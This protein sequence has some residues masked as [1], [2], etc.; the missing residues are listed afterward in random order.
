M[1]ISA[2]SDMPHAI[3]ANTGGFIPPPPDASFGGEPATY[4][5]AFST[6]TSGP[7]GHQQ[8]T[9]NGTPYPGSAVHLP[10]PPIM[11]PSWSAASYPPHSVPAWMAGG[12]GATPAGSFGLASPA[13]FGPTTPLGPHPGYVPASPYS[14]TPSSV[15]GQPMLG[16]PYFPAVNG[17]GRKA[18]GA[19]S[20]GGGGGALGLTASP[21][22]DA[23]GY[24]SSHG[25]LTNSKKQG[26]VLQ[27][28]RLAGNK[29]PG[30]RNDYQLWNGPEV[31][32][33]RNLARRPRDWRPDYN[34]RS[35]FAS[36]I[37][38]GKHRSDIPEYTDP[39]KRT[40]NS[41]LL[42]K[43]GEPAT[44][45]NLRLDPY[46]VEHIE[47]NALSR[48]HND[49]DLIQLATSP[50]ADQLR[51]Y[52][53]K[54]PWYIDVFKSRPNGITIA[55]I[56]QAMWVQLSS[57]IHQ[58]HY[59]NEELDDAHRGVLSAAFSDRCGNVKELTDR[60]VLQVDFLAERYVF[61][62]LVKGKNGMWEMKTATED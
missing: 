1:S 26:D 21:S 20:G 9:T 36:Y 55:D 24:P 62:G 44:Y 34:P 29:S 39:V 3:D 49:I 12:G 38:L 33:L 28:L 5:D 16:T 48:P 54:L 45:W 23:Y 13:S 52:H 61:L 46:H 53:P 37:S 31:Y 7:S 51:F 50:P 11:T 40:L 2:W 32:S 60:G 4:Y 59:Y 35:G 14:Y 8:R 43:T 10:A 15:G 18:G 17:G 41:L 58:R 25:H 42:Y 30:S 22:L 57:Q 47:F 56:M 19:G 27:R 6:A